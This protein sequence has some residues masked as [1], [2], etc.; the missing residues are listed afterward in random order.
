MA[1]LEGKTTNL[2]EQAIYLISTLPE[3]S[4]VYI[5]G[6]HTKWLRRL[7]VSFKDSGLVDVI[8]LTPEQIINGY[9]RGR[10]GILLIDDLYDLSY[11]C[12]KYLVEEQKCLK[13]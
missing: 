2:I 3:N 8:F 11:K 5:T 7:Q 10:R 13:M 4:K 12:Q 6:A 1:Y 9:L